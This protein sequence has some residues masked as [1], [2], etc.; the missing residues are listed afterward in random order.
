VVRHARVSRRTFYEHFP[1]KQACFLGLYSA[2]S[3]AALDVIATAAAA[4]PAWEARI[5]AAT[6]A[7]L[8]ALA[9]APALTRTFLVE[10]QAAGPEALALRRDVHRRFAGQLRR[11]SGE[12]GRPLPDDLALA[13]VGGVNELLLQ[14]LEEGHAPTDLIDG[15]VAFIRAV[16]AR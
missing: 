3:D 6:R 14:A 16:V 12:A 5:E 15:A 11:L 4:E 10:I 13:L 9:R 8:E 1:D 2:A 7:Y